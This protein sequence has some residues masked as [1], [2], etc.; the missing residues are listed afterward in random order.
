MSDMFNDNFNNENTSERSES[1]RIPES[2]VKEETVASDRTSQSADTVFTK[3]YEP[4]N[5][6]ANNYSGISW[7]TT[8]HNSVNTPVNPNPVKPEK[9][10]EKK[11]KKGVSKGFVA[12]ML[13]I[14]ILLS[15]CIGFGGAVLYTKFNNT[16]EDTAKETIVS[17]N[18]ALVINK[19]DIDEQTASKLSDKQTTQIADEVADTVVEITTEVM[20][21]SLFYGQYISQGAGSGVIISS[22]GYIVT[23]NHVIEGA[24]S[25]TV[26]LRNKE[27]Y[28]AELIGTDSDLDIALLKIDAD[29]LKAA[30]FG[31]SDKLEVGQKAVAIGNPL[32]QLGGTVTDGIISALDRDVVV[33]DKTMKLLQTDSAINPGNSGGG[34][35][36]GQG[37]LIGVVVAKSAGA[38]I[39]GLGFAVPINDVIDILDDLKE[40]GYVTGRVALGV[41]LMDVT[42]KLSARYYFGTS[43]TGCYVNAVMPDS[44]AEKAGLEEGDRI[45]SIDG[46]DITCAADVEAI[47]ADKEVG[48]KIE[49]EV[50]R[51]G[52]EEKITVKLQEYVPQEIER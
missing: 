6:T 41:E 34:L 31:D 35:F 28:E 13:I 45:L 46:T 8:P 22:D 9:K 24:S 27:T 1:T 10:K 3:P 36:D 52:D 23:N 4:A 50:D 43:K 47:L 29:N 21:T 30:K 7:N 12:F 14:C 2:F 11:E 48:D 18:G 5:N 49:V 40:Y 17:E 42:N 39:E 16:K 44:A 19:V 26:T 15:S 51:Y 37:T 25:I 20:S 32:G 33:G 38:E